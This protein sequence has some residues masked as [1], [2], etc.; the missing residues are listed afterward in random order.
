[1]ERRAVGA[2]NSHGADWVLGHGLHVGWRRLVLGML[3]VKVLGMRGLMVKA[4]CLVSEG[5]VV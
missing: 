3:E 5:C 1:M 2:G 4:L